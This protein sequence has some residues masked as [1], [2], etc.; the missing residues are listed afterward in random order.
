MGFDLEWP[1][2]VSR[3]DTCSAETDILALLSQ[4][5]DRCF[6][7]LEDSN[8][9]SQLVCSV[10]PAGD[11]A[12]DQILILAFLQLLSSPPLGNPAFLAVFKHYTSFFSPR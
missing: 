4:P 11:K 6:T 7:G 12:P 8:H 10:I 5:P 9:A 1:A 2:L 3:S